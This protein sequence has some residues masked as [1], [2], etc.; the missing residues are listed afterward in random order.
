[1]VNGNLLSI[2]PYM[3]L[4]VDLTNFNVQSKPRIKDTGI[5]DTPTYDFVVVLSNVNYKS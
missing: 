3:Y 1:M 2:Y 5:Q 4:K